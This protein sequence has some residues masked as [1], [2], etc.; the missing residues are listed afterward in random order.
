MCFV[1]WMMS[2]RS[3]VF[4]DFMILKYH[5]SIFLWFLTSF[6]KNILWAVSGTALLTSCEVFTWDVGARARRILV[7]TH[8]HTLP[9]LIWKGQE[10]N[11]KRILTSQSAPNR[12][13]PIRR[14]A[15]FPRGN[16]ETKRC[17][18][19]VRV[20]RAHVSTTA[21]FHV[22]VGSRF[23]SWFLVCM[24]KHATTSNYIVLMYLYIGLRG[25]DVCVRCCYE[26]V[27]AHR[28]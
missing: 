9:L 22:A 10:V 5:V 8:T 4:Y 20:A 6:S 27:V 7:H 2:Y 19:V 11:M 17:V 26:E 16:T 15:L 28:E 3:C 21:W 1:Y 24:Y 14:R 13:L 12:L 18:L 25:P 23:V